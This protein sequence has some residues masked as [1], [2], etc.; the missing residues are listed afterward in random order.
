MDDKKGSLSSNIADQEM[1]IGECS[2]EEDEGEGDDE[3]EDDEEIDEEMESE[4]EES[5]GDIVDEEEDIVDEALSVA[6]AIFNGGSISSQ[7]SVST[8]VYGPS[9]LSKF[10]L[11]INLFET[12]NC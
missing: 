9:P 2:S 6:S 4:D 1:D 8:S 10:R 7:P 11:I 5:E 12:T 3:E